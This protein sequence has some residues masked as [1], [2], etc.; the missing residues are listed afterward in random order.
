ARRYAA[1]W[2][3]S[4]SPLL[5]WTERQQQALQ[6]WY[7]QRNRAVT[8]KFAMR[9]GSPSLASVLEAFRSEGVTRILVLPLYPQYSGTTTATVFDETTRLV[10]ALRNQPELR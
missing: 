2:M 1:V 3:E 4:G 9:Y 6:R 8:V 10:Q 7:D 5:V